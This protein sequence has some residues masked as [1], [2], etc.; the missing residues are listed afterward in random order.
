MY[1][2]NLQVFGP[3]KWI[4]LYHQH[5]VMAS[6]KFASWKELKQILQ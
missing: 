1:N 3:Q 6:E 2:Y 5:T 4:R